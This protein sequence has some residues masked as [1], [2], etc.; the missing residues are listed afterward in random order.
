[1][2]KSKNR[3]NHKQ[4]VKAYQQNLAHA[5]HR[6]FKALEASQI[7]QPESSSLNLTGSEN[8]QIYG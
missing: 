7:P 6:W 8:I 4:K 3:K 5:K 1:M 2:P